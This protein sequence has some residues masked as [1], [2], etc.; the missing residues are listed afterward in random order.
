MIPV[1]MPR[2]RVALARSDLTA[3]AA[4]LAAMTAVPG[5]AGDAH[6]GADLT[7]LDAMLAAAHGDLARAAARADEALKI[8]AST[9][10]V[11][12]YLRIAALA[13]R[14]EADTLDAA[15]LT[16]RRA[17]AAAS[18]ARAQSIRAA[19]HDTRARIAGAGG[20]HS[21]VFALFDALIGAELSRIP[22][23]AD[24]ALWH[25]VAAH[26]LADP[27]LAA[28]ARLQQAA[29]LLARR[30][31]REATAALLEAEAVAGRLAAAP[32]R[33]EVATL[34]RLA[35][36]D[37]AVPPSAPPEPDSAGLTPREREV[38]RLL[39]N[40]LSNAE[41]ARTLYISEKTASVHVSNILAKLGVT[42]RLQAA[43]AA[44]SHLNPN[45]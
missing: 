21:P 3:A 19:A 5:A 7:A 28:Y 2:C 37:L 43:T 14:I 6:Y 29:S 27:Y 38:I 15:R 26:E 13:V 25:Q 9:D 45:P 34:A 30:R 18:L 4:D 17:D 8:A 20:C 31:R 12:R 39:S 32:M 35:R 36:I 40:G 24:P 33:A 1:R 42:S 22:G 11:A 23:P 16:G 10:D 41:I 44:V